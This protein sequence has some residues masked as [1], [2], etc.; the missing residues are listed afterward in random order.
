MAQRNLGRLY[1]T[2]FLILRQQ[3]GAHDS[4]VT[5]GDDRN[6]TGALKRRRA[7]IHIRPFSKGGLGYP[8]RLFAEVIFYAMP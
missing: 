5:H 4:S 2:A 8:S 3:Q 1:T 7:D 6:N